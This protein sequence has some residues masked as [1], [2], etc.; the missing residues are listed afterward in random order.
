M[1]IS[2]EQIK[3]IANGIVFDVHYYVM[4]H[5]EEYE[6][7]LAEENS[8]SKSVDIKNLERNYDMDKQNPT[9]AIF[10]KIANSANNAE[11]KVFKEVP[12]KIKQLNTN[13]NTSTSIY[14]NI[15]D[16]LELETKGGNDNGQQQQQ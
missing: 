15:M 8:T 7:F 14:N 1:I 11:N 4:E 9:E 16:T 10:Q 13:T 12:P 6:K 5:Q 2:D 3:Q